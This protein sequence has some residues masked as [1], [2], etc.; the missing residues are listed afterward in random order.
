LVRSEKRASGHF[1]HLEVAPG[2]VI[3]VAAWLLDPVACASM[4]IGAPRGGI[5]TRRAA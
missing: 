2:V 3:V 5:G 4:E 1:V